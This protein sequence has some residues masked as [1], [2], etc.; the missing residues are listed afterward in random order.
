MSYLVAH[1][2]SFKE[3]FIKHQDFAIPVIYNHKG[4][5]T[6]FLN[7]KNIKGKDVGYIVAFQEFNELFT[8]RNHYQYLI[9][10]GIVIFFVLFVLILIILFQIKEIEDESQRLKKFIDIQDAIVILTDGKKFYFA[11]KSFL[12]FFNYDTF[13][14]FLQEHK[15]ICDLFVKSE[16]LFSLEDVQDD[17]LHW[18]ESML[19]LSSRQRIVSMLDATLTPHAFHV[20]IG[21]YDDEKYVISFDDISDSME[22][23]LELK[24]KMIKDQ[25]T[26][27]Y[28]RIYFNENIEKLLRLHKLDHHKTGII[29]FDIDL[30][31]NVNDTYGHD[32]G[33]YILITLVRI[34]RNNIRNYDKLIRWGG[35]EFIIVLP[36]NTIDGVHKVAENIRIAI[37][38]YRFDT[39]KQITCSFGIEL[40]QDEEDIF[41]TIKKADEKLYKAKN[42]GRNIVI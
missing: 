6:L 7:M 22:E 36:A 9:I 4:Y 31:K 24:H 38:E 18:V 1:K 33:D 32:I 30:F 17:E 29:F 23:R 26:N 27:S 13:E 16:E 5:L 20:S 21:K 2:T 35:E 42:S 10:S 34:V 3:R 25:L 37:S 40:H 11:N 19:K 39:V 8:I 15:C 41:T 14:G 28:N 12:D